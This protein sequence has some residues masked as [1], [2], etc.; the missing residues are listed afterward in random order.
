MG[1][2]HAV[3]LRRRAPERSVASPTTSDPSLLVRH[4]VQ[5]PAQASPA[6]FG[7]LQRQAGNAATALVVQ[8]AQKLKGKVVNP[9]DAGS[10]T[11]EQGANTVTFGGQ[12]RD[13][14]TYLSTPDPNAVPKIGDTWTQV[15]FA[16]GSIS[17]VQGV[18]GIIG[19]SIATDASRKARN[20]YAKQGV[21]AGVTLEN[22]NLKISST[23]IAKNIVQTGVGAS[24]I[25]AKTMALSQGASQAAATAANQASVAAGGWAVPLAAFNAFRDMRKGVKSWMR[26]ARLQERLNSWNE[27]RQKLN[28]LKERHEALEE[29]RKEAEAAHAKA[30]QARADAKTKGDAAQT[31]LTALQN[32]LATLAAP[33]KKSGFLG[34]IKGVGQDIKH[35]VDTKVLQAK[36]WAKQRELNGFREAEQQAIADK[37]E[38]ETQVNGA[39]AGKAALEPETDMWLKKHE[40][41]VQLVGNTSKAAL[42]DEMKKAT[43]K[44]SSIQHRGK[45]A[46]KSPDPPTLIEIQAYAF[47]KNYMGTIKKLTASFGGLLQTAAGAASLAVAIAAL[48]G[49]GA[50]VMA[51]PIGWALAGLAAAVGLGVGGYKAF[52]WMRKRWEMSGTDNAGN[53]RSTLGRLGQTLAIWKPAGKSRR[54]LYG[55]KLL[56]YALGDQC[57]LEQM[58]EARKLIADLGISWSSLDIDDLALAAPNLPP[59]TAPTANRGGSVG[60]GTSTGIAGGNVQAHDFDFQARGD[61]MKKG[62]TQKLPI[63]TWKAEMVKKN[64]GT[65]FDAGLVKKYMK[66][67]AAKALVTVKLGS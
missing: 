46:L 10:G 4:A 7:H 12:T 44:G 40:E 19:S 18:T 67:K 38:Y 15:G 31:E 8:R 35:G 29:A 9:F 42:D 5:A 20:Q 36:I 47:E 66:F 48:A 49:G 26:C 1:A 30:E 52:K 14:N 57:Y 54:E 65:A 60:A 53:Q 34:A 59:V 45:Q 56:G 64:A 55:K 6:A 51:T 58:E 39:V 25:A 27:P 24:D 23:D 63:A 16:G 50:L 41:M 2:E 61:S 3:L 11:S 33:A 17:G 22:R 37:A 28:E 43:G 21:K 62:A 32:Q 13:P